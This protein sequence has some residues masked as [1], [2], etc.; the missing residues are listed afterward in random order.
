MDTIPLLFD[1]DIGSDIDD[2]VALAYLLR[3]PRCELLGITMVTGEPDKRAGLADAIVQASERDDV[4]VHVGLAAPLLIAPLQP[5]AA[6][7]EVL[8]D[9]AHRAF[10]PRPTATDFLRET[11][12]ARPGEITL[13]ATGPLTNLA[14]LFALDPEIPTLLGQLVVM[15]GVYYTRG[16]DRTNAEWNIRNDPHAA[17]IVFNAPVPRLVAVGLDVTMQCRMPSDEVRERFT[18]AGPPLDL[19]LEMAEVWF[20]HTPQITFHDPLAAA[21]IFEPALCTLERQR[22]EVETFSP[23]GLGQTYFDNDAP[24][25][26]HEIA[27]R[28]D[29]D[30]FFGHYF[31][32]VGG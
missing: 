7:A 18:Q 14:V 9:R 24:R 6:Q 8:T 1:T 4:P 30:A 10:G 2:A 32:T 23:R 22:I 21:L 29:A 26:P 25:K 16:Y 28:V 19:V 31:A 20:R 17:A 15:G 27:T 13:L 12:R 5:Q 11:I 3:E